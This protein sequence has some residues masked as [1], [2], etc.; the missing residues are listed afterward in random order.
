MSFIKSVFNRIF[1]IKKSP[2]D[3]LQEQL[4]VEMSKDDL[5]HAKIAWLHQKLANAFSIRC[6]YGKFDEICL[7]QYHKAKHIE[8]RDLS[9]LENTKYLCNNI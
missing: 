5:K 2:I 4:E 1:K 3:K 9:I 8:H 7:M 6:D